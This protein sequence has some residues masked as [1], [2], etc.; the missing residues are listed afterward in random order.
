MDGYYEGTAGEG[1][2][3]EQG[4]VERDYDDG[5]GE[6]DQAEWSGAVKQEK[7]A[8]DEKTGGEQWKHEAAGVE[9]CEEDYGSGGC[10]LGHGAEMQEAVDADEGIGEAYD[11]AK[12]DGDK[13]DGLGMGHSCLWVLQ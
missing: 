4:V 13:G 10:A 3:F 5:R 8:S 12:S 9:G 11:A 2:F 7:E 1:L 6:E